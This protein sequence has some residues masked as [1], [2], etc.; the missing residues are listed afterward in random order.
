MRPGRHPLQLV[1]FHPDRFQH[2]TDPGRRELAWW[3]SDRWICDRSYSGGSPTRGALRPSSHREL[4]LTLAGA[5]GQLLSVST[6]SGTGAITVDVSDRDLFG[7]LLTMETTVLGIG[8]DFTWVRGFEYDPLGRLT[9]LVDDDD[10]DLLPDPDPADPTPPVVQQLGFDANGRMTTVTVDGVVTEEY[11][12]DSNGNRLIA[13]LTTGGGSETTYGFH[14]GQDRLLVTSPTVDP[15][16]PGATTYTYDVHGQLSECL[17]PD[18]SSTTYTY[19]SLGSLLGVDDGTERIEYRVDDMGRRVG[20]FV[21]D[22]AS[23]EDERYWLYSGGRLPTAELD[24]SGQLASVFVYASQG[25]S[26]DMMAVWEVPP[27]GGPEQWVAYRFLKDHL[28]SVRYVVRVED[29]YVA[30]AL[31]Y[32]SWGVVGQDTAAG[33]QP[34]GYAGGLYDP[35]TGLVRFGA[36]DYDAGLGRWTAKDPILFAGGQANVWEYVGS[37][38]VEYVDPSGLYQEIIQWFRRLTGFVD[39]LE[40]V[41][42]R[43]IE[44]ADRAD[45]MAG[46]IGGPIGWGKNGAKAALKQL[47]KNAKNLRKAA[48]DV[49][50][51]L[52]DFWRKQRSKPDVCP[53]VGGAPK[54]TRSGIGVTEHGVQQKIN[55]GVRSADELDALKNPL[56]VKPVKVDSLGR[57]SQR[58]IG[59]K[60]EV[61][62]NP[63]TGKII[64]VN[65]TSTKKAERLL[66][67]EGG[68]Q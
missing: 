40:Y 6:A 19:D 8:A 68:G 46:I 1:G 21:W 34:F 35:A 44:A 7:D 15:Y 2:R 31:T 59:R 61:V 66:R 13:T 24:A 60:A 16:D 3:L 33:F 10:D 26:P 58:S 9:G 22:G 32:D 38:P 36:R 23:L 53:D 64:S 42:D 55:R 54:A 4:D 25:H 63:E 28:G 12:Y 18:G 67:Q 49:A 50:E 56:Q 17:H 5:S 39:G 27:G 11:V 48:D 65:P 14:D 47:V 62:T 20:R 37:R 52:S 43:S 30:Q 45:T 57:P 51:G 41:V 29:G